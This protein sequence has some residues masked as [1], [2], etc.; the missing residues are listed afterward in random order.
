MTEERKHA[1]LLAATILC[2]RK[3]MPMLEDE[4]PNIAQAFWTRHYVKRAIE[5]AARILKKIDE[6]WPTEVQTP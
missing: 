6:L 2:A 3:M 4:T 5:Q 1:V